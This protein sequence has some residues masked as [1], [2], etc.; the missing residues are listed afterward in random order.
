MTR[1]YYRTR[2]P[3]RRNTK[4]FG[5]EPSVLDEYNLPADVKG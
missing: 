2:V 4:R 3:L 1:G 5:R